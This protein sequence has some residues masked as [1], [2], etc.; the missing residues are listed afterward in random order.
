MFSKNRTLE[1]RLG[2]G[3]TDCFV[4]VCHKILRKRLSRVD[5]Q[6]KCRYIG[7]RG[8]EDLV[9][10]ILDLVDFNLCLWAIGTL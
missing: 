3:K 5:P 10:F 2:L 8:D 4:N 6:R 9:L 1:K 7:V